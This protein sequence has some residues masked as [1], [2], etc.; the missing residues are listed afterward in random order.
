M[1][2]AQWQVLEAAQ[3]AST[4]DPLSDWTPRAYLGVELI[5]GDG[6]RTLLAPT[7]SVGPHLQTLADLAP[8]RTSHVKLLGRSAGVLGLAARLGSTAA[9]P[10][11]LA[12]RFA[13]QALQALQYFAAAAM[14]AGSGAPAVEQVALATCG[15]VPGSGNKMTRCAL[16]SSL[17]EQICSKLLLTAHDLA[18]GSCNVQSACEIILW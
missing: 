9:L 18:K 10:A 16:I 11:M 3:A 6:S 8:K 15:A 12:P 14:A 2:E 17:T 7:S 13:S 1:Y 4:F 5:A